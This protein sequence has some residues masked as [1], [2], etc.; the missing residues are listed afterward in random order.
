MEIWPG[1]Q[2]HCAITPRAFVSDLSQPSHRPTRRHR[3]WATIP[4]T[5]WTLTCGDGLW[6]TGRT[7]RID[8][9]IKRLID[10]SHEASGGALWLRDEC[11]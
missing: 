10:R 3:T 4:D 11:G 5:R 1:I 2:D 8:L 9:R 6:H 7:R